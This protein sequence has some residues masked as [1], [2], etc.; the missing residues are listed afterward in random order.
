ME[1]DWARVYKPYTNYKAQQMIGKFQ[2]LPKPPPWVGDIEHVTMEW[3]LRDNRADEV[4]LSE[5]PI[6][7]KG[8]DGWYIAEFEEG[9][10]IHVCFPDKLVDF[11]RQYE[12]HWL[13]IN[14]MEGVQLAT[15][16]KLTEEYQERARQALWSSWNC[17]GTD[18]IRTRPPVKAETTD[19]IFDEIEAGLN[20]HHWP[21]VW[22]NQ[23]NRC[24]EP[25]PRSLQMWIKLNYSKLAELEL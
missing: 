11:R 8:K 9:R 12:S 2:V 6:L 17:L 23:C 14:M 21:R 20:P 5:D 15:Q 10:F 4:R 7:T 1:I 13:Q 3:L 18:G 24:A 22:L 25:L 16:I 19:D